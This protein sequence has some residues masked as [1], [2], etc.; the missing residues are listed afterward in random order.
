MISVSLG[1][2]G[3]ATPGPNHL[4]TLT[5]EEPEV[6]RDHAAP[7]IETNDVPSYLHPE[8][9]LLG[10]AYDSYTDHLFLRLAPGNAFRVV[11][12]PDHSIKREFTAPDIPTTG[13][14]DIAIRSRDRHL[15]LSHPTQ[16]ALIEITLYG[17]YIRTID[18]AGFTG[19]PTGVAYD[20]KRDRLY[21]LRGGDLTHL[22]S[23]DLEGS[24]LKGTALAHDVRLNTLA[25]D[26]D[27]REFYA[28]LADT[29]RIGVFDEQGHLIRTIEIPPPGNSAH[30]DVGPRSFLRLF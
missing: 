29:P 12:R 25:Y 19:A 5:A 7:G 28:Q 21:V 11:D 1:G 22:I 23:Y 18:L 14:G 20:Q 27:A 17:K 2:F 26:S 13:G 15:F 16:P 8:D 24:R 9:T 30:F 10:L 3:C 4:Y 6:I